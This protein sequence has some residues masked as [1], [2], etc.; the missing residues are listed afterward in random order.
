LEVVARSCR[1]L[2]VEEEEVGVVEEAEAVG[3]TTRTNTVEVDEDVAAVVVV[4]GAAITT[5]PSIL[6]NE[7]PEAEDL[8]RI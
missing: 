5:M 8:M 2:I 1:H 6:G 7:L 3:N 4:V